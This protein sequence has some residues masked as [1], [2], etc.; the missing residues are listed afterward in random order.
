M[1]AWQLVYVL[2]GAGAIG[3]IIGA[4]ARDAMWWWRESVAWPGDSSP[5]PWY[6]AGLAVLVALWITAAVVR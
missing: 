3:L 2:A 5:R 4:I 1:G 6:A